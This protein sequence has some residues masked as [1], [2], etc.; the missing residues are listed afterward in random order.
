MDRSPPPIRGASAFGRTGSALGASVGWA[1]SLT[2]GQRVSA[3]RLINA[4]SRVGGAAGVPIPVSLYRVLYGGGL[5]AVASG[6][7]SSAAASSV[8]TVPVTLDALLERLCEHFERIGDRLEVTP[9]L[10]ARST[11]P[12]GGAGSAATGGGGGGAGAG[13]GGGVVVGGALTAESR[14]LSSKLSLSSLARSTSKAKFVNV[15][16][17]AS[18]EPHKDLTA[19]VHRQ[20]EEEH[21]LGTFNP[22]FT[23]SIPNRSVL[24]LVPSH[25]SVPRQDSV[26]YVNSYVPGA[27]G[28]GEAGAPTDAGGW[29]AAS[30]GGWGAPPDVPPPETVDGQWPGADL[31]A[32]GNKSLIEFVGDTLYRK[33]P[34]RERWRLGR[35]LGEGGNS[36]VYEAVHA[37]DGTQAAVKIIDKN[38]L[39]AGQA[40]KRLWFEVYAF[41]LLRYSGGHPNIVELLEVGE[42]DE[43]VY[44]CM[45]LLVGGELFSRITDQGQYTEKHAAALVEAMLGAL[46]ICH[47]L[48]ITHRDV[49]PENWVFTDAG[50]Q[51]V[52]KLI[53]FGICF[54]SE[55]PNALCRSIIGTPL[56]VAP[57]VLLRQPYGPEADMWS[58]GV[59]VYI[60]L[61]GRPPFDD[62]D[63]IKLIKK[64]KY[65]SV[66]FAGRDWVLISEEGKDFVSR[67]LHKDPSERMSAPKALGHKWLRNNRNEKTANLFH[68]AQINVSRYNAMKRWKAAIHLVQALNR[69]KAGI[70]ALP[71]PSGRFTSALPPAS[72]AGMD[73]RG[74][75]PGGGGGGANGS[76]GRHPATV[77]DGYGPPLMLAPRP[78]SPLTNRRSLD[79]V[80]NPSRR[81]TPPSQ[82]PSQP[83]SLHVNDFGASGGALKPSS[84]PASHAYI[85]AM[86]GAADSSLGGVSGWRESTGVGSRRAGGGGGSAASTAA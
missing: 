15:A 40:E 17:S 54:Y 48:N 49:K 84:S 35:K 7:S 45:E 11:T 31:S 14:N 60:M 10:P 68:V 39:A 32:R 77:G 41:K 76:A 8:L 6:P 67:L 55:D 33:G 30:N 73:G 37:V 70:V 3:K 42:D 44:L 50:P 43:S 36:R 5:G 23:L 22:S 19:L 85:D 78:P 57:E 16:S 25:T 59:I 63:Q 74:G 82:P 52:V 12:A 75:P 79:S 34:P 20:E 72:A 56:Y 66:E 65:H 53:D 38:L 86:S 83:A 80:G 46:S 64:I 69:M 1:A 27:G 9:G 18:L 51:A 21:Q 71:P 29:P 62:I 13:A 28:G 4:A 61:S 81:S 47:R 24:N 26:P 2:D 58:L